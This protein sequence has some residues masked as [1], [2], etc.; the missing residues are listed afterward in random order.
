MVKEAPRTEHGDI[1]T[2]G[3]NVR[4]ITHLFKWYG[5]PLNSEDCEDVVKARAVSKNIASDVIVNVFEQV[6]NR[7]ARSIRKRSRSRPD[8]KLLREWGNISR[9]TPIP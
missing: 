6:N 2:F 3:K 8:A 5:T 1:T 4:D 7:P 9:T